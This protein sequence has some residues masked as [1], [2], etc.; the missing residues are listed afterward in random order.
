[1]WL[2][3]YDDEGRFWR[4]RI[5]QV[6]RA[7]AAGRKCYLSLFSGEKVKCPLSLKEFYHRSKPFGFVH[8]QR[9]YVLNPD[10]VD[11]LY[12]KHHHF[13]ILNDGEEI[14]ITEAAY[15]LLKQQ[16]AQKFKL[17]RLPSSGN[18]NLPLFLN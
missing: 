11:D 4:L 12:H 2:E 5:P 15:H 7:R 10:A 16:R 8:A 9:C 17:R 3:F 13:A 6:R 1:M 14:Y 18:G